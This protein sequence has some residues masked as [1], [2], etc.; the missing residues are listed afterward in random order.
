VIQELIHPKPRN[1]YKSRSSVLDIYKSSFK[2]DVTNKHKTNKSFVEL[3][4]RKNTVLTEMH[5]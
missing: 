4:A 1:P 2:F 5:F 3:V